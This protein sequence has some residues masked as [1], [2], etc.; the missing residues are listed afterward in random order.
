[1]RKVLLLNVIQFV[2]CIH[3]TSEVATHYTLST[4]AYTG[5]EKGA[6]PPPRLV[7]KGGRSSPPP[8]TQSS[9]TFQI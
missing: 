1:M 4:R 9:Y 2:Y 7:K 8:I 3:D 5:G 6:V